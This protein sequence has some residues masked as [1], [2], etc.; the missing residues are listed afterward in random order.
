MST[1]L[2]VLFRASAPAV[3]A[4]VAALAFSGP[5]ALA[6]PAPA[7][8][9]LAGQWH[10]D[11]RVR[12]GDDGSSF[13]P[14]SSGHGL[15]AL[16]RF[17]EEV[18]GRFGTAFGLGSSSRVHVPQTIVLEP[19][20]VTLLAWVRRN[21]D[22]GPYR[23]I[24]AKGADNGCSAASYALYTG[25]PGAPGLRFYVRNGASVSVSPSGGTALWDGDWHMVAG[26]YD[27]A[28][29]RLYVD[30]RQAGAGVAAGG[31]IDYALP[32]GAFE[33][34]RFPGADAC[35]GVQ[36][37]FPGQIDETR[38]YGRALTAAE[39]GRL[40]AD[41]GPNPPSLEPDR[42]Q[43]TLSVTKSGSGSGTVT[44]TPAGIDCGSDCSQTYRDGTTVTLRVAPAAGSG[45]A[46]WSGGGCDGSGAVCTVSMSAART[47]AASFQLRPRRT[48]SAAFTA[49]A[50]ANAR[51][52]A[53]LDASATRGAAR[54]SWD[55]NG[56]G[57]NDLA[58][59]HPYLGLRLARRGTY[60]VRL[61]AVAADGTRSVVEHAVSVGK[62]KGK[63]KAKRL[64]A[65]LPDL[66]MASQNEGFLKA[67]MRQP[68][69]FAG[70]KVVFGVVEAEGCFRHVLSRED[71]PPAERPVTAEYYD[72]NHSLRHQPGCLLREGLGPACV[73]LAAQAGF[74]VFVANSRVKINGITFTPRDGASIV[75]FPALGRVVSSDAALTLN[76]SSLGSIGIHNGPLNLDLKSRATRLTGG[77]SQLRLFSFDARRAVPAIGGF[78][79]DG[80]TDV[81]LVKQG[82][83]RFTQWS[84]RLALPSAFTVF[85]SSRPG[86]GAAVEADND[87]GLI[88]GTLD[89]RVPE[90]YLG[91]LRLANLSFHYSDSGNKAQGCPAKWWKATADIFLGVGEEPGAGL[92]LSPPPARN[93]VAFCAGGFHSAG[94]EFLFGAPIPRP[95]I[96]PGVFLD[97]I[98]F[99]MLLDSP[100]LLEGNAAISAGELVR[101]RGGL[102]AAFASP[103]APYVIKAEDAHGS[104]GALAGRRLI[105]TSFALG[106]A[107]DIKTPVGPLNLATGY[108][109]YSHPG[110]IAAGGQMRMNLLFFVVNAGASAEISTSTGR[111][112][113]HAGGE[114]CL[115]AGIKIAG[116]GACAG[117][118]AYVSNRGAV[119]CFNV[120]GASPGVGYRWGDTV[121][122]FYLGVLGDGCKPSRY[123]EANVHA[124]RAAGRSLAGQGTPPP[125]AITVRRGET[126]K[127]IE[128]TGQGGAPAVEVRAPD[129]E[130][131]TTRANEIRVGTRLRTL[132][133]EDADRTWIGI[134]NAR[135]GTY[136]ITPLP[137]SVPIAGMAATRPEPDARITASV[138]GHGTH[139]VLHYDAGR[140][141]GRRVTFVERGDAT[142][143]PLGSAKLGRGTIRFTPATGPAGLR[144][145]VGQ[146]E[147]DGVPSPP[148]V[149]DTFRAAAPTRPGRP[150][151]LR[152]R[153]QGKDLHVAWPRTANAAAYGVRVRLQ[154]GTQR[155]LRVPAHR[156]RARIRAVPTTQGGVVEVRALA[157]LG[158][159]GRVRKARFRPTARPRDRLLLF[160]QLGH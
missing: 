37:H 101:A 17:A 66:A 125:L 80:E 87:R 24:A 16:V 127:N 13:T 47:V 44:S 142:W 53:V 68:S 9:V 147:S 27:G 54:V 122:T 14:D 81:S 33:I 38:V 151:R 3:L 73:E 131:L 103:G 90:A 150:G 158:D 12:G 100:T 36:T 129:G 107:V 123:W 71:I 154:N 34:G 102:L 88:L 137:G 60:R 15:R 128:L 114:V 124:A 96:F 52:L 110:Y 152:L 22:P 155:T 62:G 93:G 99:S 134:E 70:V 18:P 145:I 58:T 63:A 148:L 2:T 4:A 160:S 55:I 20:A 108:F 113:L 48:V 77:R 112:N 43:R 69:C 91:V 6:A 140:T 32:I 86:G 104:L 25:H 30:G 138:R 126:V 85:G 8:A 115:L 130:T 50:K 41:A 149:L 144:E 156:H 65:G 97:S 117:A 39:L 106:G 119:A 51:E 83:R 153:R 23:N 121:P 98:G 74:D 146:V 132:A 45:F 29:V 56:D 105:S 159:W 143:R 79:L 157:A 84:V 7:D 64:A 95:Q 42:P 11:E 116:I 139:R 21:D 10:L 94:G 89:L 35:V 26:T 61:T 72:R 57:R 49:P 19:R 31:P 28:S 59:S 40:A 76:G 75:V 1:A 141:P 136:T 109:L 67:A 133:H 92:R 5:V 82:E 118:D 135:P 111:F 120:L 78:S 46:G